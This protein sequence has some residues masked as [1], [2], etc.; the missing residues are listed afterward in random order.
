MSK[1]IVLGIVSALVAAMTVVSIY[2]VYCA[3]KPLEQEI[4]VEPDNMPVSDEIL[5]LSGWIG[6]E[7]KDIVSEPSESGEVVGTLAFNEK[8]EYTI[9]NDDWYEIV[10]GDVSG[11]VSSAN[12]LNEDTGYPSYK[13]YELDVIIGYTDYDAPSTSGFKSYMDYRTIT[14]KNS[15]QYKLQSQYAVTGDYGIRMVNGRYC[16]AVGSHFTSDIGQ[17]FDL[18]LTNG[19]V[20]PCVLADQK[21]DRHTDSNNII[22]MHN[23]CMSEFVVDSM[24]LNSLVRAHGDISKANDEWRYPVKTVRVY[25]TNVFTK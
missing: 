3:N 18:I 15:K 24:S 13:Q 20:I 21:A 25:N 10:N 5:I 23:G 4:I 19:T 22:T 9:Y 16:V 7:T 17:Y 12:I 1:K 8:I 11:Y 14:S 6:S 2:V